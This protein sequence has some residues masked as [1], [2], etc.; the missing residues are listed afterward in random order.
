MNT[1]AKADKK[2]LRFR[3]IKLCI[4]FSGLSVFAQLYL[5]QP[6]LPIAADHFHTTVGDSSMLVSSATIGMAAGLLFFAFKADSYSRK[7]L[8]VFSLIS[9]ALLTIISTCIPSLFLLI[10]IGVLKGFVISGVSAVALAYLTE[11]VKISVVGLAISMYLSG[12]TIGGMSGR[13]LATIL[14][15]EFG[16][17]NAVLII[18]IESLILGLIFW[19]LFPD[20]QF[21]NPQKIDYSLKIKQMRSFLTDSYM[22]RLYFIAA[23]LMGTFVSIYNYLTFRL[24]SAPFSLNHFYIAF[25]FLMYTFGVFGTMITSRLSKRYLQKNILQGSIVF[26]AAGTVLLF[27]ENIYIVIFGLG[28]LT[29]SF[30][31]AHTMASQMTA[32]HAKQGKSSATSIYWLF[33]YFGSSILGSGTGYLL[34]GTSWNI[35]ILFL[36]FPISLSFVLTLSNQTQ[37]SK[38]SW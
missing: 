10:V 36:I 31:A 26:M 1:T 35:F 2:S 27:S 7:K 17:R 20:S 9:S 13:I 8:M 11:E 14:A 24:E 30:F 12:N 34:H 22:L 37:A 18:G 29:L 15:G 5:F 16:W 21:F 32:L 19:K 4:F 23:L 3:N 6:L 33:Y 28:L 25:I 38:P